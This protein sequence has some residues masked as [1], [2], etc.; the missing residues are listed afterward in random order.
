MDYVKSIRPIN[1]LPAVETRTRKLKSTLSQL[2][3]Q[4][5]LVWSWT[6]C[7]VLGDYT[8]IFEGHF[9][10]ENYHS[11]NCIAVCLQKSQFAAKYN[12]NEP[13]YSL[14]EWFTLNSTQNWLQSLLIIHT[15]FFLYL[16]YAREDLERRLSNSRM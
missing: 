16:S 10:I 8:Q 9:L 12:N 7:E 5:V 15:N 6:F 3:S 11:F 2:A 13:L 1:A 14:H 4:D